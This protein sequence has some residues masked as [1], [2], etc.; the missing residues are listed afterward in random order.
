MRFGA[1]LLLILGVTFPMTVHAEQV[2]VGLDNQYTETVSDWRVGMIEEQSFETEMSEYHYPVWFVSY[3][4]ADG[5]NDVKLKIIQQD[6]VLEELESYIPEKIDGQAFTSLDAVSFVDYNQ[7]GNTDIL[8]V[9]T[10]EDITVSAVY[11]GNADNGSKHFYLNR[12]LSD[13]MTED[14]SEHT[15]SNMLDY[16]GYNRSKGTSVFSD[17]IPAHYAFGS[18]AGAW[19]S[20]ID[21]YDD[22]TF[23]GHFWDTDM[24]ASGDGYDSTAF[25]CECHGRFGNIEKHGDYYYSMILEEYS[26]EQEVGITW[27]SEETEGEYPFRLMNIITDPRGIYPGTAY[28]LFLPGAPVDELPVDV[29]QSILGAYGFQV[30]ETEPKSILNWVLYNVDQNVPFSGYDD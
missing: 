8:I 25:H 3:M 6:D 29:N 19:G 2:L 28:Y 27:I 30:T 15:I 9:K 26:T 21:L 24:G 16:C 23:D 5:E 20:G 13:A 17:D 14:L 18:G 10:W 1:V 7:D 12:T 4:P 11:D 22:G